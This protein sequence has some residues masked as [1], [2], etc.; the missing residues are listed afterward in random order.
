MTGFQFL[1]ALFTFTYIPIVLKQ[2]TGS[3]LVKV[4]SILF[5]GL[6]PIV[7]VYIVTPIKDFP[8]ACLVAVFGL[9]MLAISV[10]IK[11]DDTVRK[12]ISMVFTIITIGV[13]VAL[14]RNNGIFLVVFSSI[15]LFLLSDHRKA[16][17]ILIGT[18]T[19]FSAWNFIVLP[20]NSVQPGSIREALS[21]PVQIVGGIYS[22]GESENANLDP[23]I[24]HAMH[25]SKDEISRLYNPE[26]SD[27]LK[28]HLSFDNSS[29][30][31][32]L[33]AVGKLTLNHPTTALSS[34]LKTTEGFWYPFGKDS[35]W[36]EDYPYY[37][38]KDDA[39]SY[40][41]SGW[42]PGSTW[43][44]AWSAHH[45]YDGLS[46]ISSR[47]H[48]ILPVVRYAYRGASYLWLF[49]FLIASCKQ[50]NRGMKQTFIVLAPYLALLLT[51]I[52]GPCSSLRYTLPFMFSGPI[53][54]ALIYVLVHEERRVTQPSYPVNCR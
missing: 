43:T 10:G 23:V 17:M 45:G 1:L 24:E 5:Y 14:T 32:F 13:L 2:I 48:R 49:L 36:G 7:P 39:Y 16:T 52:A 28:A 47:A 4:V 12:P 33:I 30:E 54:L 21:I 42:F 38:K 29:L 6:I 31:S 41:S 34:A 27:P 15:V 20:I 50:S 3:K 19:V 8:H 11:K 25:M 37:P 51:L 22:S 9:H 44:D 26:L 46:L 53:F 18:L 35:Y 40:F